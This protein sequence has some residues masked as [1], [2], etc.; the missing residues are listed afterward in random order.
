MKCLP[1]TN[2]ILMKYMK[3]Y[4]HNISKSLI[5]ITLQNHPKPNTLGSIKDIFNEMAIE[6][7]TLR[8]IESEK[9]K[10]LELPTPFIS[11]TIQGGFIIIKNITNEFIE[12]YSTNKGENREKWSVFREQCTGVA[13]LT[14]PKSY[15]NKKHPIS[16][17][18][19]TKFFL[20]LTILLVLAFYGFTF[21]EIAGSWLISTLFFT[22]AI[23]L[24]L[25]V[26]LLQNE[27]NKNG[28]FVNRLCSVGK[29]DCNKIL[30]S[31]DSKVFNFLSWS[32]L[33]FLYFSGGIL[34][35]MLSSG[36]SL[37][38]T[39]MVLFLMNIPTLLFSF[40][41][42]WYQYFKAHSWCR[43]CLI[44]IGLFW[45]EAAILLS[46]TPSV[47]SSAI[48]LQ[49][50]LIVVLCFSL[51]LTA[52][53]LIKPILEK[54]EE[55]SKVKKQLNQIKFNDEVVDTLFKK[56]DLKTSTEGFALKI[57]GDMENTNILTI[58]TNPTCPPCARAHK[59][60]EKYFNGCYD[61]LSV[62]IV[63]IVDTEND[64]DSEKLKVAR[65]IIQIY[66]S[67][68][69]KEAIE[70]MNIWYQDRNKSYEKW[71]MSFPAEDLDIDSILKKQNEWCEKN[72][73]Q[74]TPTILFNDRELPEQYSI[75]D[76]KYLMT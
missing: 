70:A 47:F 25:S 18:Q 53:L 34:S 56:S 20:I 66:E 31:Q 3:L 63:F 60:L 8:F 75:E 44:T 38:N 36:H 1:Q 22:K 74:Y 35:L 76:I 12:Y 7:I 50:M 59:E 37:D 73:I 49:E 5:E 39:I 10:L 30:N 2:K 14:F 19:F 46:I 6:N 9:N 54:A 41:S 48:S 58:I 64:K 68:G 23:G 4:N 29:N 51:P 62:N 28:S 42:V 11:H 16:I 15:Q 17:Y 13:I 71:N 61:D 32:E 26:V 65:K 67:K 27:Y 40:Y 24:A 52:L 21:Y 72:K 33:G 57:Q 43:F 69:A 55:F 45:V